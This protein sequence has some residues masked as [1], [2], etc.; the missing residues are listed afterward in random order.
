MTIYKIKKFFV[1]AFEAY[2]LA[3]FYGMSGL[4]DDKCLELGINYFKNQMKV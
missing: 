4:S 1:T 2:I 3:L